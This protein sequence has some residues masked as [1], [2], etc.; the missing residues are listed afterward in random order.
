MITGDQTPDYCRLIIEGG[1]PA[2]ILDALQ[3]QHGD[4]AYGDSLCHLVNQ[5]Y[6]SF[7]LK[8][9]A[10]QPGKKFDGLPTPRCLSPFSCRQCACRTFCYVS[11]FFEIRSKIKKAYQPV[12]QSRLGG[13]LS[14]PATR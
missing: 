8:A 13:I 14:T 6:A 12:D 10:D 1:E 7:Y 4:S 11:R 3:K 9:G 2:A 5:D